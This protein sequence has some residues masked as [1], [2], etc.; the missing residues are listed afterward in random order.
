M[1]ATLTFLH[2]APV[3]IAT[4]NRLLTELAPDIPAR[5]IVD[6]SLLREARESGVTESL[7]KR[8]E[9]VVHDA[10]H[11]GA[12]VV[13]CTCSTIGGCAESAGALRV[14]RPMA[15]A[16]VA[17]GPRILL[18]AA[19]ASTIGPTRDLLTAVATEHGQA[20]VIGELLCERAWSK[21]EQ[22]DHDGYLREIAAGIR[23]TDGCD[24]IVLAQTS[25]ADATKHLSDFPVPVLSS[26]R[27]GLAAAIARYRA[28]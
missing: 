2:T 25:M 9:Q 1:T 22:G 20:I 4:F 21:F 8:V 17:M 12:K 6:E 13:L 18:A 27:L 5:H 14:D 11:D 7:A 28:Q 15:E 19:L 23:C 24:V 3:H 26:P 16:A 10:L